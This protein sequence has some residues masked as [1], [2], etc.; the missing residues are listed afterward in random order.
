MKTTVIICS[1]NRPTILHATVMGILKQTVQPHAIVLSLCDESSVLSETRAL[2]GVRCVFG[3]KGLTLQRN[4]AIPLVPTPFALYLDDDV[5]L[6]PDYVEKMEHILAEDPSIAAA[7]GNVV[8]DGARGGQGIE[9]EAAIEA[10]LKDGRG[11]ACTA[12][13]IDEFYGCNMFVRSDVLRVVR[14][15]ERL[16]LY[17][18]LE[19]RDFLWRCRQHGRIVRNRGALIAHLGTR[20][21]RTSDVRY[22]Y[23]KIANPWYLWRKS[24][25]VSLPKLIVRYWL[26]TTFANILRAIMPRQPQTADYKKRLKGNLMA[27]RDLVLF[28]LD[29][30]NI[31]KIPDSSG[32]PEKTQRGEAWRSVPSR[33]A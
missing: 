3:P 30:E 28:R 2:P 5:E 11:G 19:D 17:G 32:P 15:D 6:A 16:P 4:T 24:V 29:P 8:A 25:S 21:G 18:W 12:V 20:S 13:K 27:Y 9:R 14:F 10:V 33:S 1:V 7:L 23:L 22:G 26:K 31:L